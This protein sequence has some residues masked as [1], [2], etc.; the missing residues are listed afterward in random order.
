MCP[1]IRMHAYDYDHSATHGAQW[2]ELD[3]AQAFTTHARDPLKPH[4]SIYENAQRVF[5]SFY[6]AHTQHVSVIHA[7]KTLHALRVYKQ[8]VIGV[9]FVHENGNM[10]ACITR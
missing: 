7:C 4:V 8:T 9:F 6:D 3:I 2:Q 10:H 1:I 5:K